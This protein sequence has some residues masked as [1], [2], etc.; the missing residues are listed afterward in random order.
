ML[1]AIGMYLPILHH[2]GDFHRRLDSLGERFASAAQRI[3]TKRR[4]RAW[5]MWA[6][7]QRREMI[8][9]EALAGM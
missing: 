1:V 5:R 2:V 9:G 6:C 7:W 3:E 8:A 4:R